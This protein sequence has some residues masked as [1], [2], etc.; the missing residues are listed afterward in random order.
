MAAQRSRLGDTL[1]ALFHVALLAGA[2]V[3]AVLS[4]LKGNTWR[5]LVIICCLGIYYVMVLDKPVRL[6]IA[7]RKNLRRNSIEKG[8]KS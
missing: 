4:L 3:T 2:A 1:F 5:F 8:P 7:R 6:E